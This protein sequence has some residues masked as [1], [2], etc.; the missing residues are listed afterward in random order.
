[1]TDEHKQQLCLSCLKCCKVIGV[2][3]SS[4]YASI[5]QVH[6]FYTTRGGRVV[7]YKDFT[8]IVFPFP[9]PHLTEQGC[10]IYQSRPNACRA[11]DGTKDPIMKDE[12]LWGKD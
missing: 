4:Y 3:I 5:P 1:M 2:P 8:L 11:Y 10:S 6:E 7:P 12:C 9:C